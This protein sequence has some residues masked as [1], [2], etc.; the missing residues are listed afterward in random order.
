[1]TIDWNR[2][3]YRFVGGRGWGGGEGWPSRITSRVRAAA[4]VVII[5]NITA[6]T[7]DNGR[8]INY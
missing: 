1:M 7:V 2:F 3:P 6:Q 8:G 4:G 5:V